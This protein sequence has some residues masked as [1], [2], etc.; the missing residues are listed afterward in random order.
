MPIILVGLIIY[1]DYYP[2][3]T[4]AVT[5][6]PEE[7]NIIG[8]YSISP[9]FKINADY[10]L[11]GYNAIKEKLDNVIDYC[12]NS[13]DMGQCFKDESKKRKWDCNELKDEAIDIL[14]DFAEKF[15]ECVNLEEDGVVCRFNFDD[16]EIINRPIKIFD[17]LLKNEASKI[18]AELREG[19]NTLASAYID[20]GNLVYTDF[21]NKNTASKNLNSVRIM[22]DY[23]L[24]KPVIKDIFGID[25]KS[26]RIPLSKTLL[27]YK[28]NNIV[29][30]VEYPGSSFE[31]PIPANKVIDLPR[32]TGFKFCVKNDNDKQ[33]YAYDADDKTVK[34]RDI[35]YKFA[36]KFPNAVVPPPVKS[37]KAEDKLKAEKSIVLKWNKAKWDDGTDI[38]DFDHYNIYCSKNQLQDDSTKEINLDNIK[39][40][41]AVKSSTNKNYDM[42][43]ADINKCEKDEIQDGFDYYFT[44][45]SVT[46]AKKESKP[47]IIATAKSL[48]DLAPGI[49][50]IVLI[51]S[52]GL[53]ERKLS[54]ACVVLPK[55]SVS[56]VPG[57][58][59]AGFFAPEKNEDEITDIPQDEK[60]DYYLHFFKQGTLA[61]KLD[62]CKS[63]ECVK[64]GYAPKDNPRGI[65]QELDLRT[66]NKFREI[67]KTGNFFEEGQ[68]YCFTIIAKD[69]NNNIIKNLNIPYKFDK[70]QQWIDLENQPVA[71]GFLN[72]KGE[73][74]YS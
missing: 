6:K 11:Q 31:A 24:K 19:A 42:W 3:I 21:D 28:K 70:P 52:D 53:N 71:K 57:N 58:I 23:S 61:A 59:W 44:V 74:G 41:M 4:G 26:S 67:E 10:N 60:L 30:F 22:M 17:I 29:K 35:V 43:A 9:S 68:N 51:N 64:L 48:D 72:E 69:K 54:S 12:K 25:D 50:K 65:Q 73:I 47:L 63:L 66:F 13:E 8:A 1:V 33:V 34:L 15:K 32:I 5:A 7:N 62:D 16:R 55:T 49:Q 36:V 2:I 46:T 45:T 18:K 40:T 39:P 14:H 37:L 56:G 20:S 38:S 27:L